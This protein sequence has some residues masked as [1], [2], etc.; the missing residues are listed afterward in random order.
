[1]DNERLVGIET[2]LAFQ[3]QIADQLSEVLRD[4]QSQID[5][6]RQSLRQLAA[7]MGHLE[8]GGGSEDLPEEKPPHY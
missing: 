2:K 4:Q 7:R 6:V 5:A 8:K 3:E 1:M